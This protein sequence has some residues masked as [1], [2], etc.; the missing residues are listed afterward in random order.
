[1][2]KMKKI[3]NDLVIN[4]DNINSYEKMRQS[5]INSEKFL[6]SVKHTYSLVIFCLGMICVSA[7]NPILPITLPIP[8][9]ISCS[10]ISVTTGTLIEKICRFN[11]EKQEKIL[12]DKINEYNKKRES[13]EEDNKKEYFNSILENIDIPT[14]ALKDEIEMVEVM[15]KNENSYNVKKLEYSIKNDNKR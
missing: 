13:L 3:N 14:E 6:I 9:M 7:V 11:I 5:F 2:I 10:I 4:D 12:I 1:M 8:V 15:P